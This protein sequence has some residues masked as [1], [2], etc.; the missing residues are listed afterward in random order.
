MNKTPFEEQLELAL[1]AMGYDLGAPCDNRALARETYHLNISLED[2]VHNTLPDQ[3]LLR[4]TIVKKRKFENEDVTV[5]YEAT[6]A[7]RTIDEQAN[8]TL[9]VK[10]STTAIEPIVA[11]CQEKNK[12]GQPNQDWYE[13]VVVSGRRTT[14]FSTEAK[15][16]KMFGKPAPE[17][18]ESV[19]I[20]TAR[21]NGY[22]CEFLEG[23][24]I[25]RQKKGKYD[26]AQMTADVVS[27]LRREER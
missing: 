27:A 14:E 2:Q 12:A 20:L 22:A 11:L 4:E 1:H 3:L 9:R 24:N 16:L 7:P 25:R 26:P 18:K 15:I 8:E 17:H 13:Q 19:L 6:Y 5:E 23:S 21:N 10:C